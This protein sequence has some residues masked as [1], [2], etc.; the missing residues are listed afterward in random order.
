[1]IRHLLS[2]HVGLPLFDLAKHYSVKRCYEFYQ[3]ASKWPIER[4]HSFRTQKLGR[5]L[6][7][8]YN[9]VPFY[10]KR[11]DSIGFQPQ[12]FKGYETLRQLPILTRSDIQENMSDLLAKGVDTRKSY[13]GSSSGSTGEPVVF[14]QNNESLSAGLA[15]LYFIWYRCGWRFGD[16]MLTIW[17]N[18]TT[19]KVDWQ[20]RSSKIKSRLFNEI[21]FP[22]YLLTEQNRL[23]DVVL[24]LKKRRI[25]YIQGYTNAIYLL[26]DYIQSGAISVPACRAIFTTAENLHEYQRRTIE[27][28]LGPV[29]DFYG[30]GEIMGVAAQTLNNQNYEIVT[31]HTI[32]EFGNVIDEQDGRELVLTDLDNRVMPFIRYINGDIAVPTPENP[33]AIPLCFSRINGRVSDIIRLPDG[34]SLTVPSFFG[35]RLLK[36]LNGFRRYQIERTEPNVIVA[37]IEVDKNFNQIDY[38]KL[39]RALA[40]YLPEAITWKIELCDRIALSPNGKFKL[41]ID[42]TI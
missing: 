10:R 12:D 32:L 41:V 4:Q 36:D 28:V 35:S 2:Y 16:R 8:A 17:G 7:F 30:C 9:S 5:L 24:L 22:A 25:S 23:D 29:F 39:A 3:T 33:D 19:V 18:P 14:Y 31:P 6:E 38:E 11:F 15:A 26:A 21:K 13:R 1:M 37:R 40:D 27:A 42:R 20:R 34:G